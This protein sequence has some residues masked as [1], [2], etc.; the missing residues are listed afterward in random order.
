MANANQANSNTADREIV[1]T[2]IFN[3]PRELVYEVWTKP[4][5]VNKW[6]GPDG[7]TNTQKE[8]DLKPGGVWRFDMNGHG[9]TFPNKIVFH[10]VLKN[11]KLTY[12]HSGD[13]NPND[14]NIFDVT[15]LFEDVK[16]G[17]QLTMRTLFESAEEM[18][19]VMSEFGASE[20]AV[21][22]MNNLK[23][24]IE[25]VAPMRVLSTSRILNYPPDVVFRAFADPSQL[26]QWWG[27]KGF[28]NTFRKCENWEGGKWEF[29]MHGPDGKDYENNTVFAEIIHPKL[30]TIDH[31]SW[32]H[33]R[34]TVSLEDMGGKTKVTWHQN[35]N[36][37]EERE[38]VKKFAEPGNEQNL[39]K[40]E[41]QMEKISGD[42]QLSLSRT[43]NAPRE[44]VYKMFSEAEHLANW[45]GPKG[46]D[47]KVAKLDVRPGG[48]FL[49]SMTTP[50][51]NE[52]WGKFKYRE[53]SPVEQIVFVNS[54]SDKDG[55][56]IRNPWM[57][58]WPLEVYN[59]LTLSE[60]D[61]KTTINLKG[62]PIN[63]TAEERAIFD[64]ASA[65]MEQGF[66]GTFDQLEE[67]L[68]KF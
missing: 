62:G 51:G 46:M 26:E 56:D 44:L 34:L 55:N 35:F 59:V 9:M 24:Y 14:P 29:T 41:A 65:N 12:T 50:D 57:P 64:G 30:F 40:L 17:T 27:P 58:E 49:Y 1:I 19:R 28:T 25:E 47:L 33:F 16:D 48:I 10:E 20:G 52:M 3:A 39:D 66:K 53:V 38:T 60:K 31:L 42:K 36:T 8:M 15:V 4:E 68:T 21:Q 22:H 6:W 18:K 7:F 13:D 5:H 67:Y 32:P 43:Y 54:F 2:R 11:E 23:L 63:C 61:G 37:I 45:W